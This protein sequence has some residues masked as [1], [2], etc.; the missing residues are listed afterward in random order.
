MR[1]YALFRLEH[2]MIRLTEHIQSSEKLTRIIEQN[3]TSTQNKLVPMP[4]TPSE[5]APKEE[6]PPAGPPSGPPPPSEGPPSPNGASP[7]TQKA[8]LLA[9]MHVEAHGA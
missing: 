9:A 7:Q 5:G 6:A 8:Q 4:A 3:S 1:A 2:E